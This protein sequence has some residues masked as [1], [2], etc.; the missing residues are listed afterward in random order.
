[1]D[2]REILIVDD[3]AQVREVLHQIFLSAS[4]RCRQAA[5]GQ[6]GVKVSGGFKFGPGGYYPPPREKQL[7][8]LLTGAR[9]EPQPGGMY[10]ITDAKFETYLHGLVIPPSPWSQK[11]HVASTPGPSSCTESKMTLASRL[12]Y[13]LPK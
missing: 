3:D 9:A 10:L 2:N 8:S 5:N 4:Y 7:K 6:E 13:H 12:R 11:N 1:M